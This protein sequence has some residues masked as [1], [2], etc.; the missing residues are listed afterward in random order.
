M[1][2]YELNRHLVHDLAVKSKCCFQY[3]PLLSYFFINAIYQFL[4][5]LKYEIHSS[6]NNTSLE[7][8]V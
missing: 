8:T 6:G 1:K 5:R 2:T 3:F 4:K 7:L